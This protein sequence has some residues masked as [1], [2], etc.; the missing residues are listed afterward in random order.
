MWLLAWSCLH[1]HAW[2]FLWLLARIFWGNRNFLDPARE[3]GLARLGVG[4]YHL[5]TFSGFTQGCLTS[6]PHMKLSVSWEMAE[7]GFLQPP[8]CST[9]KQATVRNRRGNLLCYG[10]HQV[11]WWIC[12]KTVI[13]TTQC[14]HKVHLNVRAGPGCCMVFHLGITQL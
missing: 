1:L 6:P 9:G 10:R 8:R 13:K 11:I 14:A 3:W 12:M 5:N 7:L 4:G 2:I